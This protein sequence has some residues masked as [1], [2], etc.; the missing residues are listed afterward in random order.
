[1]MGFSHSLRWVGTQ[2]Q[3]R[4]CLQQIRIR[5]NPSEVNCQERRQR[6]GE[7]PGE[8]SLPLTRDRE[9]CSVWCFS[10]P[11]TRSWSRWAVSA[12]SGELASTTQSMEAGSGRWGWKQVP[13]HSLSFYPL[14]VAKTSPRLHLPALLSPMMSATPS[15]RVL[16][17]AVGDSSVSPKSKR[18]LLGDT[19]RWVAMW[20]T[21]LCRGSDWERRKEPRRPSLP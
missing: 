21:T 7:G 18:I 13:H 8:P 4:Q 3:G 16:G 6:K 12:A 9:T 15:F 14:P 5:R 1:M 20:S 19:P 17:V 10:F 2:D 11:C